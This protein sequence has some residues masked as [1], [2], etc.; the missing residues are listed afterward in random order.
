MT[1]ENV[2][3]TLELKT[4]R[5]KNSLEKQARKGLE[6]CNNIIVILGGRI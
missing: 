6:C 3:E 4:A 1:P 2:E 5:N